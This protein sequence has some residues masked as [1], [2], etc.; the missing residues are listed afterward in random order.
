MNNLVKRTIFGSLF[1]IVVIGSILVNFW[2][3][4]IVMTASVFLGVKEVNRLLSKDIESKSELPSLIYSMSV[5]VLSSVV[6]C[7]DVPFNLGVFAM[8]SFPLIF[9]LIPFL[10]ALFSKQSSFVEIAVKCW[11]SLLFVVLPCILLLSMYRTSPINTINGKILIIILFSLIWINDIF[12][13]LTGMLFGRHKLF[14]RISVLYRKTTVHR[15]Q[16]FRQKREFFIVFV[17]LIFFLCH[18]HHPNLSILMTRHDSHEHSDL[19]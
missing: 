13:Y 2:A 5:F 7:A 11:T 9:L 1:V 14:E 6:M 4:F 3:F 8:F 10:I 12:A 17:T 16:L 15:P 18:I 19:F